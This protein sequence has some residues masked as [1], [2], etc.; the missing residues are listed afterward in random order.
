MAN[1]FKKLINEEFGKSKYQKY[2]W[3]YQKL[4]V[5][6]RLDSENLEE[7]EIYHDIYDELKEEETVE[8]EEK[9][10]R[11]LE[12]ML[13]AFKISKQYIVIVIVYIVAFLFLFF[14]NLQFTV[15]TASLIMISLCFLYKTY[16]F[17]INKY[18]YIDAYIVIIYKAILDKILVERKGS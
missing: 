4:L 15:T 2:F 13:L 9:L 8:L 18:C 17:V 1:V 7:Q 3:G 14:R 5:E 10:D 16:E 12:T 11:L 6:N